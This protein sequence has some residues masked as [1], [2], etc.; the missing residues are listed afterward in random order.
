MLRAGFAGWLVVAVVLLQSVGSGQTAFTL[1][2]PAFKNGTCIAPTYGCSPGVQDYL[3]PSPPLFWSNAP[4]QTQSFVLIMDDLSSVPKPGWVHWRV[5][6]IPKAVT[7]LVANASQR[8]DANLTQAF[9]SRGFK[10]YEGP[11][12][13]DAPNVHTYRFRLYAL[14]TPTS[15]V[16]GK[17]KT[18]P[19]TY[20]DVAEF[21]GTYDRSG[22]PCPVS[23]TPKAN[24]DDLPSTP[25]TTSSDDNMPFFVGISAAI[26]GVG[27]ICAVLIVH[28][29]RSRNQ[30][31]G[32]AHSL[33]RNMDNDDGL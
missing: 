30:R 16:D 26:V 28:V 6:N 17:N 15:D 27:F 18:V 5:I 3:K 20:L 4:A 33:L 14:A 2:S 25:T 7:F 31:R 21:Y 22:L 32:N 11:C 19:S 23:A 13:P 24:D 10:R 29:R 8:A 1:Q 12:P 9:N